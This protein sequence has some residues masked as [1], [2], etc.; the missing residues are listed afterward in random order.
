MPDIHE[1]AVSDEWGRRKIADSFTQA[2]PNELKLGE[3][4]E[5]DENWPTAWRRR[6][7][8]FVRHRF[9]G[10]KNVGSEWKRTHTLLEYLRGELF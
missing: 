5:S 9:G 4:G 8:V 1:A 7:G 10:G 3:G 6:R 2:A